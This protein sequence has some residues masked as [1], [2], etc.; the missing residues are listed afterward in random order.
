MSRGRT[1][2]TG[3]DANDPGGAARGSIRAYRR[4]VLVLAIV[5]LLGGQAFVAAVAMPTDAADVG[6]APSTAGAIGVAG[7]PSSGDPSP[8][9]TID[10]GFQPSGADAPVDDLEPGAQLAANTAGQAASIRGHVDRA[11]FAVRLDESTS[12]AERGVIVDGEVDAVERRVTALER[13]Y[14]SRDASGPNGRVGTGTVTARK[15][16]VGFEAD[17]VDAHLTAV[18]AAAAGL[19]GDVRAGYRLD[20][21]I[22][23]LSGRLDSLR[24]RTAD[25]VETV[26]GAGRPIRTAPVST[27]NVAAAMSQLGVTERWYVAELRSERIELHVRAANGTTVRFGVDR[28]GSDAQRIEGGAMDDPTVRVHTDY[29]VVRALE[30][31]EDPDRVLREGLDA[32]RIAI[33]GVGLR[34]SVKYSVV[35]IVASA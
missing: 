17:A 30:R 6:R 10:G 18:D 13:R 33:D 3:S 9:D 23:A 11:D 20:E 31:G 27:S 4:A 1:G 28:A 34:S 19:P 26:E 2:G 24:S 22:E 32:D 21:R 35:S 14:R 29:R 5:C 8:T 25:A 12:T 15:A 16:A 7:E